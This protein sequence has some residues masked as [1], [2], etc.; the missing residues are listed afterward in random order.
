MA[1]QISENSRQHIE[2]VAQDILQRFQEI[3]ERARAAGSYQPGSDVTP[4]ATVNT[5]TS[6]AAMKTLTDA[7][8]ATQESYQI[9]AREPAIARVVVA[10]ED[11][12]KS[13]YYIC[14]TTGLGGNHASYRSPVGR[15]AS[16]GVGGDLTLPNGAWVEVV[17][18]SILHP[19]L[20]KD[21]W[22]ST[23]TTI[24][25]E[26]LGPLSVDWPTMASGGTFAPIARKV[27]ISAI[28]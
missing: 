1:L 24:E 9:L 19:L 7:R 4:F 3:S 23:D 26:Q 15:L 5:L 25:G 8:R 10:D 13:T 22:D 16:L 12:H 18:R 20:A 27:K 21:G 28:S 11:D 6:G 2:L 17:E 14:R